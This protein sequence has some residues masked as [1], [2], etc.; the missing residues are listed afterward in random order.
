MIVF[1]KTGDRI[2]VSKETANRIKKRMMSGRIDPMYYVEHA[3]EA[4]EKGKE[5][6]VDLI[7]DLNQ[8][9]C[10]TT[11]NTAFKY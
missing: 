11:I 8:I 4:V 6:N 10:I 3:K 1:L 9:A 5:E 7:I 2:G